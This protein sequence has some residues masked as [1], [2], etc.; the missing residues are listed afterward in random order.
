MVIPQAVVDEVLNAAVEIEDGD[1]AA[2]RSIREGRDFLE[3]M[4]ALGRA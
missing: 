3:A 4:R 2:L 1:Q